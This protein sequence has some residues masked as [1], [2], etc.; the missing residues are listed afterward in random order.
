MGFLLRWLFAFLLVAATINPTDWNYIRWSTD[1]SVT[2]SL[3]VLVGLFLAIAYIVYLNATLRSIGIFGVGLV[4]GVV[5]AG[6]W[7]LVDFGILALENRSLNMWLGIFALSFVLGI[8]LNWS[9][10]RRNLTGQ[11][12]VDEVG[13]KD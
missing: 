3:R 11:A 12:D 7:V 1:D 6:I 2:L 8:G 9:T 13:E 10:V 5:G 4:L